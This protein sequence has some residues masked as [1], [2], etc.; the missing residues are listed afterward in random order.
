MKKLISRRT[1][2]KTL[3]VA[4]VVS[5]TGTFMAC[6]EETVSEI[7]LFST[8]GENIEILQKLVDDFNATNPEIP[9]TLTAPADAGTVL[10]TRMTKNDLPEIIAMGGSAEF[11]EVQSTGMLLDLSSEA[12]ISTI[13]SE[14]L[15]MVYDRNAEK[16]E[17]VYGVPY[18]TNA[19]GVIYNVDIFNENGVEVPQ[20]WDELIAVADTLKAA[21]VTPFIFCF[22]DLWTTLAPWNS[23]TGIMIDDSFYEERKANTVKFEGTHEEVL[24]KYET[25]LSYAQDDFMGMSYDDGN[26]AL[27]NGEG[28]MLINGNWAISSIKAANPDVNIDMFALPASNTANENTITSGVDVL[29]AVSDTNETANQVAKDFVAFMM[30]AEQAQQYIDDQFAFSSVSG[31]VQDDPSVVNA[32][33]I[34]AEG[35]VC[36][37]SDHY[38]PNGFELSAALSQFGL[39]YTNEAPDNIASVMQD[40]DTKFDAVNLD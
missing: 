23:L 28:A 13:S 27:A 32:Q 11:T 10:K 19:S 8:K 29:F 14:Y 38:Y 40:L 9:V 21:G 31:V 22:K 4:G 15:Q 34:I 2:L 16:E 3:A 39:N 18:A 26:K 25:L 33:S 1:F 30:Q 20:T 24:E 5:A 6:G 17:I 36:N 7:E 12:Y 37:F 35:R